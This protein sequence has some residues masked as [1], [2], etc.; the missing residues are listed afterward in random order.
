MKN[1]AIVA[2]I[3][4]NCV[5]LCQLGAQVAQ[6]QAPI[7]ASSPVPHRGAWELIE[8]LPR[9][10]LLS[11]KSTLADGT[12]QTVK[13][14]LHSAD[15]AELQCGH[16]TR[17]RPYWVY[18]PRSS[19]EYV[20]PRDQVVRVRLENEDAQTT[21]STLLGAM[22]GATLGGVIGYNC[23]NA[24]SGTRAGGAIGL[25]LIGAAVVGAAAHVFPFVK[26]RLIYE[27]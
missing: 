25:G 17:P 11:V 13:C 24:T 7:P 26:G 14:V 9:G 2:V 1:R 18:P 27:R 10:T 19:D 20:F 22:A 3:V 5:L 12:T 16:W 23:C 8:N 6:P 15:E 4:T 21:E